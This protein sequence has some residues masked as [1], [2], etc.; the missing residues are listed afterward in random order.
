VAGGV[1][2]DRAQLRILQPIERE[3]ADPGHPGSS[4]AR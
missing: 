2:N 3:V 4:S 1:L